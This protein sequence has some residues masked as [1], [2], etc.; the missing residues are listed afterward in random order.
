MDPGPLV[1]RVS[2]F[3]VQ[4]VDQATLAGREGRNFFADVLKEFVLLWSGSERVVFAGALLEVDI[5]DVPIPVEYVEEMGFYLWE[6]IDPFY[7]CRQEESPGS[8]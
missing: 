3:P 2:Q 1:F 8:S 5:Q 7:V 6:D 4:P